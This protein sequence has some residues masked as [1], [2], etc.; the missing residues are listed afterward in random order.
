MRATDRELKNKRQVMP[1]KYNKID[2]SKNT[3]GLDEAISRYMSK[4]KRLYPLRINKNTVIF[5]T[6]SKCNEKYRQSYIDRIERKEKPKMNTSEPKIFID[7]NELAKLIKQG[8][9]LKS[10]ALEF[11]VSHSTIGKKIK[12]Y[13]LR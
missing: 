8:L 4:A 6:K 3:D 10:I 7:K 12:E 13:G 1:D 5:V 11:N 9:T 2:S